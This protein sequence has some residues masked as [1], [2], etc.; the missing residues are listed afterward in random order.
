[1]KGDMAMKNRFINHAGTALF[2][3]AILAGTISC[4]SAAQRRVD[5][6]F[7]RQEQAL[8]VPGGDFGVMVEII[9]DEKISTVAAYLVGAN[10]GLGPG[11]HRVGFYFMKAGTAS[12]P[13][14]TETTTVYSSGNLSVTSTKTTRDTYATY[15]KASELLF[16]EED[17]KAGRLYCIGHS[18]NLEPVVFDAG[19]SAWYWDWRKNSIKTDEALVAINDEHWEFNPKAWPFVV[20]IDGEPALLLSRGE[21]RDI[22]LTKGR[23]TFS[24]IDKK[25]PRNEVITA[26]TEVDIANDD[27]AIEIQG[28]KELFVIVAVEEKQKRTEAQKGE[29]AEEKAQTKK[30]K[31]VSSKYPEVFDSSVGP[32]ESILELNVKTSFALGTQEFCVDGEP[33][34]LLSGKRAQVRFKIPNGTHT[35]SI[36]KGGYSWYNGKSKDFTAESNLVIITIDQGL[37][38]T[39]FDVEQKELY[40][41]H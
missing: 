3:L 16:I 24:I 14:S 12:G 26:E 35:L 41:R 32:G 10:P 27:F 34:M 29:L 17:F 13:A 40:G 30:G 19:Y 11:K 7:P 23:H 2:F 1:M 4:A 33:I 38:L 20:V 5:A 31:A 22:V 36:D 15:E 21:K 28:A 6:Q 37:M 8:V 9:D 25:N 18:P 39:D